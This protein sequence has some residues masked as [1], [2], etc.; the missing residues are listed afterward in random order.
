MPSNSFL[1]KLLENEVL[2]IQ[3]KFETKLRNYIISKEQKYFVRTTRLFFQANQRILLSKKM[4][5]QADNKI[6]LPQQK[7]FIRP[8]KP[9]CQ[10]NRT[11]L[12][13]QLNSFVRLT[14]RPNKKIFLTQQNSFI[15]QITTKLFYCG[16]K[17]FV[18]QAKP[19]SQCSSVLKLLILLFG[20]QLP[21]YKYITL[22]KP[23]NMD[24]IANAYNTKNQQ[25][26]R[27]EP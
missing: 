8:T 3:M 14:K 6:S 25:V 7:H 2:G 26:R 17:I 13:H 21:T 15:A 10:T 24:F 27:C 16:N 11:F 20:K 5:Y 4:I 22:Q 18:G 19:F 1:A 12:L 9:F 23:D